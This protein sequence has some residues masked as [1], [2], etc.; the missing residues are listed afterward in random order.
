M[1]YG[2]SETEGNEPEVL[3][4]SGVLFISEL[5]QVMLGL[6]IIGILSN[7]LPISRFGFWFSILAVFQLLMIADFGFSTVVARLVPNPDLE[8][9][10]LI[11]SIRKS[12]LIIVTIIIPICMLI[13]LSLFDR[14]EIFAPPIYLLGASTLATSCTNINRTFLRTI[15][16]SF[17]EVRISLVDRGFTVLLLLICRETYGVNELGYLYAYISG[18][19]IGFIFSS[20]LV[21]LQLSSI[22][23]SGKEIGFIELFRES[24]PFA[25]DSTLAPISESATRII[26]LM[27]SGTV[28]VAIFEVAWK[29]FIGGGAIVRA[30]RKSMLST[31]SSKKLDRDKMSESIYDSRKLI[32]WLAPLGIICGSFGSFLI[33]FVFS[34]DYIESISVFVI[35]LSTWAVM[36]VGSSQQVFVQALQHG[37]RFL[38]LTGIGT[39]IQISSAIFLTEIFE[40]RGAS[41]SILAGQLAMISISILLTWNSEYFIKLRVET[42]TSLILILVFVSLTPFFDMVSISFD[43]IMCAIITSALMII[44]YIRIIINSVYGN[45]CE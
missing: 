19:I 45:Q 29:V 14:K 12:Q 42:I 26:L 8:D 25:I 40:A 38:V 9:R 37:N 2:N 24:L 31:Y 36:L 16:L 43:F 33:P 10:S 34:K 21:N 22:E 23:Q 18:P 41:L 17:Q 11:K 13:L 39:L 28:A 7:D 32:K 15:G 4:D 30:I 6:A 20:I 44:L 5:A 35:L 27:A 3:R 1:N